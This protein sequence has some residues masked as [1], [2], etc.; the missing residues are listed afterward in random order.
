MS[1]TLAPRARYMLL[2][3]EVV[4]DAQR[5]G[6]LT[7]VGLTSL[8]VWPAGTTTPV[9]LGRLV[10]LLILTDGYGAG[11]GHILCSDENG[12]PVFQSPPVPI[13]F[14]GKDPAGHYGVTFT[15]LDCRFP[16]PGVYTVQFLFD[17]SVVQDQLLTVR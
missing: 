3:D 1:I 7:V 13:S 9:S 11:T 6:K 5:P 12:F 4:R 14:A 17:D 8:V 10:V 16:A 15:L 2:C